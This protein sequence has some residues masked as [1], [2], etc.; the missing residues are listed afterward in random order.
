VFDV[1]VSDYPLHFIAV[2]LCEAV[3]AGTEGTL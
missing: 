1:I 3:N 2:V